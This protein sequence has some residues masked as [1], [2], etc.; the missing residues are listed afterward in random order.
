MNKNIFNIFFAII[1]VASTYTLMTGFNAT[2]ILVTSMFIISNSF[3]N[4][5][6]LPN[7]WRLMYIK[8]YSIKQK[9]IETKYW[10]TEKISEQTFVGINDFNI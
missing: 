6:I 10:E 3:I 9:R 5:F 4:L 8:R 1:F 2:T 7:I